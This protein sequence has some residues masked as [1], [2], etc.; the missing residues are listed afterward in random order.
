VGWS[1]F[2]ADVFILGANK[3]GTK[4]AATDEARLLYGA[5]IANCIIPEQR[6]TPRQSTIREN[7]AT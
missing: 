7:Q 1:S 4:A 2:L 3:V 6:D 5:S